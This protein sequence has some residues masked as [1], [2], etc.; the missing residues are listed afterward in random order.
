MFQKMHAH[1]TTHNNDV[2]E[3]ERD[4]EKHGTSSTELPK[5][6]VWGYLITIYLL[7]G[8]I[9]RKTKKKPKQN[10]MSG[11]HFVMEINQNE[12]FMVSLGLILCLC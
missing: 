12:I 7:Q 1:Y 2:W 9:Q 6:V 5:E 3:E 4:R 11:W 8:I 10:K